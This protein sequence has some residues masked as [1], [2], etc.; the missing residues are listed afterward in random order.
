MKNRAYWVDRINAALG[1][2]SIVW[3]SGVRRVGKT[4]LCRSL[5]QVEYFDCELPSV[6]RRLELPESFMRNVPGGVI[7]LDEIHRLQNPTELLKI[8]ADH[9]PATRIIATGSSTLGASAKF[10]D[11]LV[12]RKSEVWLT[13]MI[14]RDL[15]DFGDTR[16][17]KRFL[18]GGL[19]PF[20][21]EENVRE[22]EFQE[23]VDGY[24]AKDIQELFR[25]ERRHSFQKFLELLLVN[26]GGIFEATRYARPCE[27][28]RTTI[29]NYLGVLEQTFVVH[30]IRPFNTYRPSEIVSAPKV[31]GF[32]TGFICC[33]RG[34]ERLRR[35][36]MGSLWEHFVL[37][38]LHGMLQTREIKYWR[39][40]RGREVDFV[41]SRRSGPP[42]AIECK[43]MAEEF[44]PGGLRAFRA[45][46]PEGL[47]VVVS[48]DVV[49][50]YTRTYGPL[51]VRVTGLDRLIELIRGDDLSPAR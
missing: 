19:P 44:D 32:D 33:F 12:G 50:P 9:F 49:V 48:Q 40:K 31:Y 37:N 3:L 7:V 27:V 26:S 5:P 1:I 30:V 43:W 13:P 21:L 34:W 45:M 8:A 16:L 36:D 39:D 18:H 15:V 23:W 20:F 11:T 25:L 17:E 10:R 14:L 6:R 22:A 51:D 46:Y 38:E 41:L 4:W 29:S 47:S 24:W 42:V 35:D 2:R 28:S